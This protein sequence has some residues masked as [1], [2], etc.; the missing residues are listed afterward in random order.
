MLSLQITPS[1]FKNNLGKFYTFKGLAFTLLICNIVLVICATLIFNWFS[2]LGFLTNT[3]AYINFSV[4]SIITI[5]CINLVAIFFWVIA[6]SNPIIPKNRIGVIFAAHTDEEYTDLINKLFLQFKDEVNKKNLTDKITY[7]K[8]TPHKRITNKEQ[9]HKLIEETG[10]RLVIFGYYKKGKIKNLDVQ[11]LPSISFTIRHRPIR[12]QE[13]SKL[14]PYISSALMFRNFIFKESDSFIEKQALL[15]NLEEVSSYFVGLSL[16]LDGEI[17]ISKEIFERLFLSLKPGINAKS[18]M[19]NVNFYRAVLSCLANEY[20]IHLNIEYKS[21]LINNIRLRSADTDA[22]KCQFWLTQL[23]NI[24]ALDEDYYLTNAIIHFHYDRIPQALQ[25]AEKAKYMC[26]FDN[27]TPRLSVAFLYLWK[28]NYKRALKEY[29]RLGK[30]TPYSIQIISDVIV[31]IDNLIK[32][33][34]NRPELYFALGFIN[35]AFF[36]QQNALVDYTVFMEKAPKTGEWCL[37]HDY[38]NRR[39][40]ELT[41]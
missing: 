6:R 11:G 10:A 16:L 9:A 19:K 34:P 1:D 21:N 23:E 41:Q 12:V 33:E 27:P 28:G 35:D 32:N 20:K 22:E 39:I 26:S 8:L 3:D 31:F 18:G 2:K 38:V 36:D 25:S 14:L 29:Y 40:K 4:R 30:K 5:A 15:S 7:K 24:Q 13:Y 17:E 37:L